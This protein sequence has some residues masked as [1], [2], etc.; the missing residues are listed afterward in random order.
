M[1]ISLARLAG[2]PAPNQAASNPMP[3][4]GQV[5][6]GFKPPVLSTGPFR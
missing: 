5:I 6:D 1:V 2:I 3:Q 4:S